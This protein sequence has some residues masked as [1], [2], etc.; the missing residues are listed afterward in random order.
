VSN[1][2]VTPAPALD[3]DHRGC[4]ILPDADL[5]PSQNL[6]VRLEQAGLLVVWPIE[7]E[8]LGELIARASAAPDLIVAAVDCSAPDSIERL[9]RIR[10]TPRVRHAPILAVARSRHLGLDIGLLRS[11]GVVGLMDALATPEA[12]ATRILEIVRPAEFRRR[13]ERVRCLFPVKV[14]RDGA[15]PSE[16]FALDVSATGMRLTSQVQLD[17]NTDLRLHFCLPLTEARQL[18]VRARSCTKAPSATRGVAS[19]PGSSST[20]S[21]RLTAG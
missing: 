2:I 10:V 7:D 20:R 4:V 21:T 6:R 18:E 19:R 17:P 15:P 13:A 1:A 14:T 3:S 5:L 12:L 8:T 16:E 9:R 11:Y